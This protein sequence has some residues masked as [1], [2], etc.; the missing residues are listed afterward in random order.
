MVGLITALI[1]IPVAGAIVLYIGPSEK[2]AHGRA[3]L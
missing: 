1:L 3:H 2:S